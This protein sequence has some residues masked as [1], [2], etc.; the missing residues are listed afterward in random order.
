MRD[1]ETELDETGIYSLNHKLAE[2]EY[3]ALGLEHAGEDP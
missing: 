1:D 3:K 2:K